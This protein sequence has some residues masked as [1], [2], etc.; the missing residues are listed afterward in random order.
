MQIRDKIC[1]IFQN[2]WQYIY[3]S[4]KLLFYFFYRKR[5]NKNI[6]KSFC[7]T[8]I[9]TYF[10]QWK[11]IS[12]LH[13]IKMMQFITLHD[14][15]HY[16]ENVIFISDSFFHQIWSRVTKNSL[17]RLF[18]ESINFI[19]SNDCAIIFFFSICLWCIMTIIK[20]M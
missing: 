1:Y 6:C 3:F 16:I 5:I 12:Y 19:L 18:M 20:K 15:G 11:V 13:C 17:A 9:R 7:C 2:G 8:R 14:V 4:E 10:N